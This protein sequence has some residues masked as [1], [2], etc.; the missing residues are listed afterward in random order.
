MFGVLGQHISEMG[1]LSGA[2]HA[3]EPASGN[4]LESPAP[5]V[6]LGKRGWHAVVRH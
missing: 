4:R 1:D 6:E 5:F 2:K 3:F